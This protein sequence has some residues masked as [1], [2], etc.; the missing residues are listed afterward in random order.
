MDSVP[1]LETGPPS[2]TSGDTSD[3]VG[4]E[5]GG[6]GDRDGR[7]IAAQARAPFPVGVKVT[8]I[9]QEPFMATLEPFVHVELFVMAKSPALAPVIATV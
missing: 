6:V 2:R 7:F 3:R 1:P 8:R 4:L 9:A 5:P